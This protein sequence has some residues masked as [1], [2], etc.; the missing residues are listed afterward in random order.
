M[1]VT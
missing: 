1:Q